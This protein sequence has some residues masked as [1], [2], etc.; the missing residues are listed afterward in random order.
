MTK[1]LGGPECPLWAAYGAAVEARDEHVK[2]CAC[3]SMFMQDTCTTYAELSSEVD[4]STTAWINH[5]EEERQVL[6]A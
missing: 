6:H 3:C 1:G 2:A 5:V 4:A